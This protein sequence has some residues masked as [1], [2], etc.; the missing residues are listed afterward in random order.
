[1][2]KLNKNKGFTIIELIVVIVVLAILI[3][4]AAPKL[5]GYTEKA[6]IAQITN[7]V[8]VHEN[9]IE[10]RLVKNKNYTSEWSIVN[11]DVLK[12]FK[13]SKLLYD[14]KGLV[15]DSEVLDGKYLTIPS[16]TVNTKLKGR[17]YLDEGGKVFYADN[18]TSKQNSNEEEVA[19][20]D[21]L[22]S[23]AGD[24]FL[25][26]NNGKLQKLQYEYETFSGE[27]EES[28]NDR[29]NDEMDNYSK[30]VENGEITEEEFYEYFERMKQERNEELLLKTELVWTTENITTPWDKK[31][32]V[33]DISTSV[34]ISGEAHWGNY[35]EKSKTLFLLENNNVYM[36]DDSK[37]IK[38]LSFPDSSIRVEYIEQAEEDSLT[39]YILSNNQ[40]WY[41]GENWYGMT[42]YLQVPQE[43]KP[44]ND[45]DVKN[46]ITS[47]F[48]N[49]RMLYIYFLNDG[50]IWITDLLTYVELNNTF[51][52]DND[53]SMPEKAPWE[54]EIENENNVPPYVK[55]VKSSRGLMFIVRND[56]IFAFDEI[57]ESPEI[58]N[59]PNQV[60]SLIVNSHR[61]YNTN[62]KYITF[63]L[64]NNE[65]FETG[66]G[67]I[68][69]PWGSDRK[70][71]HT[72][73]H[74]Y[75]LDNGDVYMKDDFSFKKENRL[76]NGNVKKVV[77]SD[78]HNYVGSY[79]LLD[80]NEIWFIGNE[81][82]LHREKML[83]Y[84]SDEN[85]IDFDVNNVAVVLLLSNGKYKTMKNIFP[86][87]ESHEY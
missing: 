24:Y 79:V 6:R 27:D 83:V 17:F 59:L 32:K 55:S 14:R 41:V 44:W 81:D 78:S 39:M 25:Y 65:L 52:A 34:Q 11:E 3:L 18:S 63:L 37:T 46:V 47:K 53:N 72:D 22:I 48:S 29:F 43:N 49:D 36:K 77:N 15:E 84:K 20:G 9:V 42:D 45:T 33:V 38:Q 8:R 19:K 1:M 4:L 68:N 5:L 70:V 50:S 10:A 67:I 7:D 16:K 76:W 31:E 2:M 56:G 30:K 57:D 13:E 51:V 74:L 54:I 40:L 62:R 85:I 80:N 86:Y 12:E 58:L 60:D 66:R 21:S 75:I 69:T 28:F 73:G 64:N 23:A 82:F 26:M 71:T 35:E 87:Y 61:D